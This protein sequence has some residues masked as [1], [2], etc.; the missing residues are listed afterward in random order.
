MP[1]DNKELFNPISLTHPIKVIDAS[2]APENSAPTNSDQ[3]AVNSGGWPWWAWV[4]IV[5]VVL[6]GIGT[7]VAVKSRK[8]E[9]TVEK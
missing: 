3:V 7:I 8:S 9:I 2:P 5:C 6:G 1:G 4:V